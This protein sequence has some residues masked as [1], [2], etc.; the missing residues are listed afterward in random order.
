MTLLIQ[1]NTNT[2]ID[3]LRT[4]LA[5][6]VIWNLS[7]STEIAAADHISQVSSPDLTF[8]D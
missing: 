1:W 7:P 4:L 5:E 6:A 2:Y 3:V 8:T